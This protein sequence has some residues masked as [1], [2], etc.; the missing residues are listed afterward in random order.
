[1][2]VNK[3]AKSKLRVL[4]TTC[5]GPGNV[6]ITHAL[7]SHP[8]KDI[9]IINGSVESVPNM[10]IYSSKQF[11]NIPFSFDDQFIEKMLGIVAEYKIDLIIPGFSQESLVLAE[12]K[13]RF[14][15][16]GVKI[17]C[18]S[19]ENV[20]ICHDKA[21]MSE[22]LR[23]CSFNG[24]IPY[25]IVER[26]SELAETCISMG[27]PDKVI[28][29]KP[30]I[31]NGGSRGFYILSESYDRFE[32][33]FMKKD[34]SKCSLEELLLKL[35]GVDPL[36]PLLI[37]DYIDGQEYGIDVLAKAGEVVCSV[38]RKRMEPILAGMNMRVRIEDVKIFDQSLAELCRI[39]NLDGLFNFD[40]ILAGDKS[41]LLE[42]NPRQSAYVGICAQQI[43][44]LALAI[45]MLFN[46]NK[47][48]KMYKKDFSEIAAIRYIEE[49][50]L[51]DGEVVAYIK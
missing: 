19:F 36:P 51:C 27:Y 32:E 5:N 10:D 23:V 4:L 31:C 39:F 46:D 30:T 40:F 43:N 49:Y 13:N 45:D 41:F 8:F 6:G 22:K 1:M 21:K 44:I 35:Q 7:K 37:M 29:V 34:S 25:R 12:H 20:H 14:E 2:K 26:T 24:L 15:E 33:Y 48:L 38:V 9:E 16:I 47:D 3:A 18:P 28:C 42:I 17:L 11:V 50:A